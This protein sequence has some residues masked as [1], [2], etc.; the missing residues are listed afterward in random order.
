[1]CS[2]GSRSRSPDLPPKDIGL[3]AVLSCIKAIAVVLFIYVLT[4]LIIPLQLLTI[5]IAVNF[6][7]YLLIRLKA[8]PSYDAAHSM[9]FVKTCSTKGP[10]KKFVL[11]YDHKLLD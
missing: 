7:S 8:I 5:N 2:Q 9:T 6:E 10:Q 3:V 1:M 4:A 11:N